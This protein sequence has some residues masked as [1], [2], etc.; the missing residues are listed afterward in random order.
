MLGYVR[1]IKKILIA[2]TSL[3]N[4]PFSPLLPRSLPFNF[5][6]PCITQSMP[7]IDHKTRSEGWNV[8]HTR[9]RIGKGRNDY[10][11]AVRLPHDGITS[12]SLGHGS[13]LPHHQPNPPS[14]KAPL[15]SSL[16]TP[17]Y[18]VCSHYASHTNTKQARRPN[19]HTLLYKAIS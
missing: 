17:Y 9:V 5:P 14:T 18:G 12:P 3:F 7:P 6:H 15:L 2:H 4:H 1:V 19:W 13:P 8:D 11:K 16:H 10:K